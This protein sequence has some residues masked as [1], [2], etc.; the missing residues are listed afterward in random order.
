MKKINLK[1][2]SKKKLAGGALAGMMVLSALGG[3]AYAYKDE[4]NAKIANG[5]RYLAVNV[6]FK[7]EI[8]KEVDSYGN[9]KEGELKTFGSN[10]VSAV[11]ND[12]VKYKAAEIK[13]G[14]ETIDRELQENKEKVQAATDKAVA[15]EK[16][17]QKTKTDAEIQ[18]S[19]NDMNTIIETEVNKVKE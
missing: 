14:K 6:V 15:D 12:L 7:G 16:A 10:L 2:M 1:E 19:S 8:E 3:G 4:F 13:R 9:I 11:Y 5:I 18:E 17:K